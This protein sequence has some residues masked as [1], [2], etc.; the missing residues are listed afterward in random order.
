MSNETPSVAVAETPVETATPSVAKAQKNVKK[1]GNPFTPATT[2]PPDLLKRHKLPGNTVDAV[3]YVAFRN[4]KV[5]R[6][7]TKLMIE[8]RARVHGVY[9][10][11]RLASPLRSA[12]HYFAIPLTRGESNEARQTVSND[13]PSIEIAA[14][15]AV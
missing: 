12:C 5:V 7:L 3:R 11:Q 6:N 14:N 13:S 4:D 10:K 9:V 8:Y 2:M 15:E 1:K